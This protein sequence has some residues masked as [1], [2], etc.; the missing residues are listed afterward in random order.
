[1]DLDEH[2]TL[3]VGS[4]DSRI[5]AHFR[6]KIYLLR[7]LNSVMYSV[8][9]SLSPSFIQSISQSVS[10]SVSQ[11][12]GS[13][14]LIR[15]MISLKILDWALSIVQALSITCQQALLADKIMLPSIMAA[16]LNKIQ[17]FKLFSKSPIGRVNYFP[18]IIYPCF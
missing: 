16:G 12:R 8:W 18:S 6:A 7:N 1:M 11:D 10:Q 5:W 3:F 9:Q 4:L 2:R 14:R 17:F 15:R 13:M